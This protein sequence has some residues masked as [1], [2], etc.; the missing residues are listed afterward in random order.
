MHIHEAGGFAVLRTLHLSTR[1]NPVRPPRESQGIEI[2][3]V[4]GSCFY[5]M[6]VP[7][8]LVQRLADKRPR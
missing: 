5:R 3:G 4:L 6:Q 1:Q 8:S 2:F 7:Y